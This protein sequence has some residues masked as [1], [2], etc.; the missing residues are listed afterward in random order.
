MCG[1]GRQ[2]SN[3]VVIKD[4]VALC[5]LVI[6]AAG[7]LAAGVLHHRTQ[8]QEYPW[9]VVTA[10]GVALAVAALVGVC[11]CCCWH[12]TA[13]QPVGAAFEQLP[14]RG[15]CAADP[16]D[17]KPSPQSQGPLYPVPAH[18]TALEPQPTE[19]RVGLC[20]AAG[21]QRPLMPS[22]T[23][24][25]PL[26]PVPPSAAER[27]LRKK[28]GDARIDELLKIRNGEMRRMCKAAGATDDQMDDADDSEFA[29]E[30]RIELFLQLQDSTA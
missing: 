5:V 13:N 21:E 3:L 18:V 24:L 14:E 23:D 27:A 6:L 7:G 9:A 19:R 17:L 11:R 25:G 4:Y 2:L 22:N 26:Y 8:N 28:Y 10:L 20:V 1:S 16:A 12:D 15:L 29:K 30:A